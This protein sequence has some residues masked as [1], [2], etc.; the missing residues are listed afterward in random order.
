M[1]NPQGVPVILVL[2]RCRQADPWG[3]M[4]SQSRLIGK[5]H[6][7]GRSYLQKQ[8]GIKPRTDKHLHT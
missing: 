8:Y 3:F 1:V 7:N 6:L 5:P 4:V 2:G